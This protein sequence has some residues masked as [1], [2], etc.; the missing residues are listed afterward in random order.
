MVDYWI[1]YKQIPDEYEVVSIFP[2]NGIYN[3]NSISVFK[4]LYN[5][6]YLKTGIAKEIDGEIVIDNEHLYYGNEYSET[7]FRYLSKEYLDSACV[8]AQHVL[9]EEKEMTEDNIF[10]SSYA[11]PCAFL[12]RHAIE[13]KIKQCLYEQKNQEINK[14]KL[15]FLW[16]KV[17]KTKLTKNEI[18]QL[19]K[20]IKEISS[21]DPNGESVRYGVGHDLLPMDGKSD[22]DCIALIHNAMYT[23]NVLHKIAF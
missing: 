20:F 21:L 23:F 9:Q 7:L 3:L 4:K 12:C 22:F 14:H 1:P 8:L 13:L 10:L 6:E 17:D 19:N 2:K 15:D 5:D 11:N 16:S 18:E